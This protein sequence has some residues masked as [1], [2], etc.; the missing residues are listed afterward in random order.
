MEGNSLQIKLRRL[1]ARPG[2]IRFRPRSIESGRG[3]LFRQ[4]IGRW[5]STI[6]QSPTT[7]PVFD[8]SLAASDRLAAA[9]RRAT[10]FQ[11]PADYSRAKAR[12]IWRCTICRTRRRRLPGGGTSA[13]ISRRKVGTSSA[14]FAAFFREI[15]GRHPSSGKPVYAHSLVWAL[16]DPGRRRYYPRCVVDC[17]APALRTEEARQRACSRCGG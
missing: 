11:R 16:S 6:D 15:S 13:R 8:T 12:S 5:R 9:R 7:P 2:K 1:V 17:Q 14:V 3:S 4:S 10:A